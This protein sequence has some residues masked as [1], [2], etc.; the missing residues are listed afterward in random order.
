V[1]ISSVIDG[2]PAVKAGLRGGDQQVT[3]RGIPVTAGGDIITAI[4]GDPIASFDQMI[5]YLASKKL[6]GQTV[7]ITILRGTETLQLPLT[8]AERPR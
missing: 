4:D 7:T 2:G 5:G 1:L 8:L 6:V 3:V